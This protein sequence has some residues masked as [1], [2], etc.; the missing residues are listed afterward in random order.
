M[1]S[2]IKEFLTNLALVLT[3][4]LAILTWFGVI[5][6]LLIYVSNGIL[7][8]ALLLLYTLISAA[9]IITL[10]NRAERSDNKI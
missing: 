5:L 3:C 7:Q 10:I 2:F 4:T 8:L 1:K 9:I 6:L